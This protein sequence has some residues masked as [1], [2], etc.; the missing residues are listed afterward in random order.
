MIM[1]AIYVTDDRL[2][3]NHTTT[4]NTNIPE[5]EKRPLLIASKEDNSSTSRNEDIESWKEIWKSRNTRNHLIAYW[6]FS[7]VVVC[8]EEALPLFL[9]A[10]LAGPG[11]S[12]EQIGWVLSTAGFLVLISQ[13]L[14][15]ERILT[16]EQGLGF[17]PGLKVA[18][19]MGNVPSV[20]VPI[21]LVLNG[22]TYYSLSTLSPKE[23]ET[24]EESLLGPPGTLSWTSFV[25]LV[26]LTGYL[27]VFSYSYFAVIG[28]ATG[29]TVPGCHRDEV[30]R[31]MTLGALYMR[32]VAPVFGGAL[33]SIFMESSDS[34]ANSAWGLWSVIGLVLGLGAAA[35]TFRLRESAEGQR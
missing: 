17:Y 15:A 30:A 4:N 16:E 10:R 13:A 24:G 35:L 8:V 6:S 9:I 19:V 34:T 29:R 1:V 3:S 26:L 12:P 27:R 5:G 14:A 21:M 33:V 20:L 22:G 18:S 31:I 7:F 25:F 2:V 23:A 32:A 28:M 11:L